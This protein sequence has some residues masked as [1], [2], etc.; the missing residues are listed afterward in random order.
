MQ[1]KNFLSKNCPY[2]INCLLEVS[3]GDISLLN[4]INLSQN[5]ND[6][7]ELEI[8]NDTIENLEIYKSYYSDIYANVGLCFSKIFTECIRPSYPKNTRQYK[9]E[10]ISKY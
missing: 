5:Q 6:P 3:D 10:F 1:Q 9:V 2:F 7:N 8:I 4:L